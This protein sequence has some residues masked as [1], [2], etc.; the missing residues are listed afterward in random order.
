MKFSGK[1]SSL[2][3]PLGARAEK[4]RQIL[5]KRRTELLVNLWRTI[6]FLI[7]SAGTSWLLLSEGWAPINTKQIRISGS[8]KIHPQSIIDLSKNKF[9]QSLLSLNPKLL[10]QSLMKELPIEWID[11]RRRLLPRELEITLKERIPIA[12]ATRNLPKGKENGMLDKNGHWMP[13]KMAN[14][15]SNSKKELSVYGWRTSEVK[16]ISKIL[17]ERDQ[18]GSTLKKIIV[19]PNGDL[20]LETKA[21]GKINLGI[22]AENL[23]AQLKAVADLHQTLPSSYLNNPKTVIDLRDPS[24]PELQFPQKALEN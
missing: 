10:E 5:F 15:I 22:E 7:I 14:Q 24:K 16:R 23:D 12:H 2:K 6:F 1:K 20:S 17:G 18:L 21:L 19:T 13:L 9:P 3:K 11:I 8:G 4:R